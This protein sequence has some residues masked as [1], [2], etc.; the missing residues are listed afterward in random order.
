MMVLGGSAGMSA[1]PTL[2]DFEV[3]SINGGW[4]LGFDQLNMSPSGRCYA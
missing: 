4:Q 1:N 3:A 2:R